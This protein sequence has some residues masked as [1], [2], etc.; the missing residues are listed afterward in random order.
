MVKQRCLVVFEHAIK[1]EATKRNYLYCLQKFKEYYKIRDYQSLT[2]ISPKDL[3]VMLEDYL[4]D[5]KNRYSPNSIQSIF[6][7]LELFFSMNDVILN[8]KKIR[9]MFPALE[10]ETG[11]EAYSTKDVQEILKVCSKKRQKALVHF[12]AST[13]IRAGAVPE[14][15]MK[16][17]KEMPHD[18]LALTVYPDSREEYVTFLTPEANIALDDYLDERRKDGE[19]LHED[20][21][22]FRTRYRL[23]IEKVQE[24]SKMSVHSIM[25]RIVGKAKTT[26]KKQTKNRYSVMVAH[27]L[28]K[29]FNTILKSNNSVNSN[30]AEKMMGHSVTIQLDNSYLKPT[31]DRVFEEF[32]KIIP[33]LTVDDSARMEIKLEKTLQ[34]N[35][36]LEQKN[37]ELLDYK[38]KV[39]QLWSEMQRK[40]SREM[41][42]AL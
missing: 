14:L 24:I 37:K 42:L 36:E 32:V 39:D 6:Y 35:N 4:F 38:Q 15:K 16:H 13:G 28:R 1:A 12:L 19:M 26:R 5:L 31:I 29:R 9:K 7:A 18:C 17:L 23:G 10:K 22:I 8:F 40:E 41:K 20:S 30:L 3:Q 21:P 27:G 2:E 34:E 11:N 25:H 33:E